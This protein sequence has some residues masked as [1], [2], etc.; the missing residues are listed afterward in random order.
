MAPGFDRRGQPFPK[1]DDALFP[2]FTEDF[3]LACLGVDCL[4]LEPSEL[5]AS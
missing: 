1:G 5:R 4:V 3:E 2:P